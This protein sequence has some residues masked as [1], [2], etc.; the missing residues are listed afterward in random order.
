MAIIQ[1][2]A[3]FDDRESL[4]RARSALI[5]SGLATPDAVRVEPNLDAE[6]DVRRPRKGLWERLR[7]LLKHQSD[8]D[9]HAYAEG[10]RRGSWILVV[11]APEEQAEPV[12]AIMREHGAIELR[13]RIKRWMASGWTEFDPAGIPFV[14]EEIIEERRRC[15][16][17]RAIATGQADEGDG[18]ARNVRLFDEAS[19]R[20]VGRISESELK[21]LQD[22]LEEE[23][24]DDND[25]WINPDEIDD[26]ACWP[27]ATPHLI[28]LLRDAVRD[29]PDGV[30][31]AFERD[32][33][34]RQKLR[35]G[36][37]RTVQKP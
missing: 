3:M 9:V 15:I 26:L 13:R 24:P 17:E 2:V 32:G 10:I 5:E 33:Q 21:V 16:D 8:E 19:G 14:E 35:D 27:G 20:E 31:L 29:R 6:D 1:V 4:K 25:Y 11:M 18:E 22:A 37:N 30:D 36:A 28:A 34:E 23:G 7:K 12:K